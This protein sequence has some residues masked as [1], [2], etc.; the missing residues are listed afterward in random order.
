VIRLLFFV[1]VGAAVWYGWH[2]FRRQQAR[3]AQSLKDAEGALSK[4]K[5]VN[6]ERDPK[7]GVYRPED[8]SD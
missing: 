2:L 7:T 6:L 5:T 3:V 1:F 8:S 4:R